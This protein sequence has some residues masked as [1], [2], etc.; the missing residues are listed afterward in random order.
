MALHNRILLGLIVGAALGVAVN[1]ASGGGA[2]VDGFVRNVTE[3]LGRMWL[4]ALIMVVI[5]L[6]VSTLSVGI[7]GLG[8]LR[9]LGQIGLA[10]LLSFLS[11]TV[12][13]TLLGLLVMN[14]VEPGR[15]L[16]PEVRERLLETYRGQAEG[17][18][19]LSGS[20]FG[21]DLLVR[22]V[23]RNPV[24]RTATCSPSSSSRS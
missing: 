17:A 10:T 5:P 20:S 12:L 21:I 13:S 4:A 7:A 11:L 14:T 15:G 18:M 22:I 8:S 9:R 2:A 6:I 24:K 3:P 23:P 16:H 1:L 19:G